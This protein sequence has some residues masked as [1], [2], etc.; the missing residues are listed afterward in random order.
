M[1]LEILRAVRIY[2]IIPS[3]PSAA[4]TDLSGDD[5]HIW[6]TSHRLADSW[7]HHPLPSWTGSL[8]AASS[9]LANPTKFRAVDGSALH[10]LPRIWTAMGGFDSH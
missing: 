10:R 1:V 5:F 6:R 7:P 2:R 4:G 9:G 8:V 3:L